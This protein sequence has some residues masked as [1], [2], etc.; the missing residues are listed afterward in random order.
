MSGMAILHKAEL[1]PSKLELLAEWLPTQ[2]WARGESLASAEVNRIA[3]Y[4]FDDPAGEVG[5][6]TLLVRLNDGPLLQVPLTY[7]GAPLEGA[8]KWLICTTEH[9]VLGRR[10]VYDASGDPVYA[11]ALAEAI[12]TGGTEVAQFMQV[13]DRL[14]SIPNTTH[15]RGSGAVHTPVAPIIAVQVTQHDRVTVIA[16]PDLS[17]SILRVLGQGVGV[18]D[19]AHSLVGTWD[20]QPDPVVLAYAAASSAQSD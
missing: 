8:E 18:A 20:G 9:S 15:V 19:A 2:E 4:R 14:E 3:A 5:I 17:L 13:G 16:A 1:R 12:L 10:W 7:R 6:E 11:S